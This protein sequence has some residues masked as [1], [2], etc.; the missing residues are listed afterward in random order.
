LQHQHLD[1]ALLADA[2]EEIDR[3]AEGKDL[4]GQVFARRGRKP[5]AA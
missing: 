3:N 4:P 5:C 2:L 1:I